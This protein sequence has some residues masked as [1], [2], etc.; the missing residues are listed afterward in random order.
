[1]K[2]RKYDQHRFAEAVR[3]ST[4]L[5]RVLEALGVAATSPPGLARCCQIRGF[6]EFDPI[7]DG[8]FAPCA[9]RT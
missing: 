5:K 8:D 4:S 3:N 2:L 9:Q 7:H 1:M 6:T